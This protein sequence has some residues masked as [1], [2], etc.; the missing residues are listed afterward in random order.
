MSVV[1]TS[2]RARPVALLGRLPAATALL[3]RKKDISLRIVIGEGGGVKAD[4][5]DIFS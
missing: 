2:G 1:Q 4:K 5:A 3:K